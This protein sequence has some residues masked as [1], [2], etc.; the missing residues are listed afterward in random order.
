MRLAYFQAKSRIRHMAGR[1][2]RDMS[3]KFGAASRTGRRFLYS[4]EKCS[5]GATVA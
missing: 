2:A 5:M 1:T 3:Q 4:V